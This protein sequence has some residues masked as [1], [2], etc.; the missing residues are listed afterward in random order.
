MDRQPKIAVVVPVYK[1]EI[2]LPECIE[3]ILKQTFTDFCV[4]LV[5]D[6]SPD[7]CGKICDEYAH[8]DSRIT[9]IHQENGGVTKARAVGVEASPM[10]E[11]IAFVDSDDSL[12]PTALADLYAH[13]ED[14]YDIVVGSYDRNPKQYVYENIDKTIFAQRTLSSEI[15]SAPY[16]KLFRRKLFNGNTFNT[17]RDFVM[18]EDLIMN[19]R[20]AF[21]CTQSI[22]VIP[23]CV[24]YYRDVPTG[25]M[26]TFKY[27]LAYLEKSYKMKKGAIPE[28]YRMQCMPACF[29]N[30][31]IFT[32]LIMGYYWQNRYCGKTYF[33]QLLVDDMKRYAFRPKSIDFIALQYANPFVGAAYLAYYRMV[34]MLKD[35]K[36]GLMNIIRE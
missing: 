16:A 4:V 12:P 22:K 29:R 10:T 8:K 34:R 9:V 35:L 28:E 11:Y 36:K 1:V 13:M 32:H 33:H 6:G 3:S 25:V 15:N 31:M 24:Y 2:F 21:A 17:P 30:I 26:N 19:L 5:D 18:G 20:L 14:Q 27:T 23:H 7:N